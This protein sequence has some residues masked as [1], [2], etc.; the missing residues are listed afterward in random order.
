M[1]IARAQKLN[2]TIV[3]DQF[4]KL[5]TVLRELKLKHSPQFIYNLDEKGCRLT[6]HHAHKILAEKGEGRIHLLANEY[7]ENVTVVACVYALGQAVPPMIIFKGLRKKDTYSDNFPPGS[8]VQISAKGSM[9]RELFIVGLQHFAKFKPAGRVLLVIDGTS[10]HLDISIV[11]EAEKLDVSLYCLPSN[12]THE[13]Q[14]LDRAVFRSFE[15]YWDNELLNYWEATNVP[16][17]TSK[18]G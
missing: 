6:L 17:L 8:T 15:H 9:T 5:D 11:E 16:C 14:P 3:Q 10:C 7:G 4:S 2:P 13:L 1:S 18:E 12:T